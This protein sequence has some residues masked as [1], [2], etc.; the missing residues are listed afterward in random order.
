M[1]FKCFIFL[2]NPQHVYALCMLNFVLLILANVDVMPWE[3]KVS[4][5]TSKL[6][7]SSTVCLLL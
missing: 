4:D 1:I 7:K 6:S 3:P 2:V 5:V